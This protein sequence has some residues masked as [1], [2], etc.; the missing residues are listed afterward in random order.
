MTP[1]GRKYRYAGQREGLRVENSLVQGD[2]IQIQDAGNVYLGA[3]PV[4]CSAYVEQVKRIAP[5]RLDERDS[6]LTELAEFSVARSGRPYTWW[7]APAWA[8]KSALMSWFVLHPPPGVRVVSFFITARYKGQDHQ[9]AFTDAVMEQLADLLVEPMP[10]YLTEAT[11]EPHLLRMLSQAAEKCQG[12]DQQLALVVDGLDED[13]GVTTGPEAY[14]IAGLLPARP[15][16]GLRII[17]AGRPDPPIP[18]DVPDD[19]PL[20][21]PAIVRVLAKSQS[22]VVVKADMQRELK[23]LLHGTQAE[24]DLLGL[25]T[26]AGGGLSTEDLEELTG[27][28]GYEI[29]ETLHAVAGRTFSSRASLWQPGAAPLVYV[30]GHEELQKTAIR[31]LG[32][33]RLEEYRE[34]LHTWAEDYRQRGWPPGTPEYLLRG[35]FRMLHAARDIPRLVACATDRLRHDRMLDVT[36]GDT[37]ALAEI[38]DTQEALLGLAEPDL[39]AMGR[40]AIHRSSIVA[41][42]ARVPHVL[43]MVWA[44]AGQPERAEAFARAITDPDLKSSTLADLA[45]T[46]ARMSDVTRAESLIEMLGDPALQALA[47]ARALAALAEAAGTRDMEQAWRLGER[48]EE[49]A[50]AIGNPFVLASTLACLSH[51]AAAAGDMERATGLADRAEEAVAAQAN[52]LSDFRAL[53]LAVGDWQAL[54]LSDQHLVTLMLLAGEAANRKDLERAE[55]LARMMYDPPRQ[56]WT[57]AAVAHAAAAASETKRAGRLAERAEEA[58][59]AITD[60]GQQA[61]PLSGLA[62]AAA[63]AGDTKQ[64]GRLVERAEEAVRAITDLHEQAMTLA[65]MAQHAA[66]EGDMNWARGLAERAEEAARAITDPHEQ[67]LTLAS[68]ARAFSGTGNVEWVTGLAERA[69]EAVRAITDPDQQPLGLVMLA[70]AAAD[71]GYLEQAKRLAEQTEEVARA[72]TGLHERSRVLALLAEAVAGAGDLDRAE[73]LAQAIPHPDQQAKALAGLAQAAAD[74]GDVERARRMAER[75]E[76]LAETIHD[77]DQLSKA[78]AGL[79]QAGDLDR[80]EALAQTIPDPDQQS[81]A[82]VSLAEAAAAGGDLDRAEALAQAITHPGNRDATLAHLARVAAAGGDLERA[83][84]LAQAITMPRWQREALAGLV[85]AGDLDRAEALAQTIPDPDQQSQALVSL[86]EAAAAGGDLD[87]AEALVRAADPDQQAVNLGRLA[88]AVA[89]RGD[90][91]RAEALAQA[92][93]DQYWHSDA[94]SALAQ[95]AAAVGDLDR[96]RRLDERAEEAARAIE[97]PSWQANRLVLMARAAVKSGDMDRGEALVQAITDPW[98]YA[99]AL[100][101]LA[102][103]MLDRGDLDRAEALARVITYPNVQGDTLCSLVT[104]VAAAGDLERASGLVPLVTEPYWQARTLKALT[105]RAAATGALDKAQAAAHAIPD[106]AEQTNALEDL[107]KTA[108]E[109]GDLDRAE[110]LAQAII[111]LGRQAEVLASVAQAAAGAGDLDRARALDERAEE[112]A[113]AI[114]DAKARAWRLT[115]LARAAADK[116]EQDRAWRLAR[117][118]EESAHAIISQAGDQISRREADAIISQEEEAKLLVGLVE[119]AEPNHARSLIARILAARSWEASLDL[120]VQIVPATVITIGDEYL[121]ET[122]QGLVLRERPGPTRMT[123]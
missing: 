116:G 103:A 57:L 69:E 95:A 91:D 60:Q 74:A 58:I 73:A 41:C 56:A 94:M 118:A 113:H 62:L 70:E 28:S 52:I 123:H 59:R 51:A 100:G 92:I 67:A 5:P 1:V 85:Q 110:V 119:Y 77:P 106:L 86:A 78:L 66:G 115:S 107:A 97:D 12:Q 65:L 25:V 63:A 9:G 93:T 34:R 79:V 36:G 16:A 35:Y 108:L 53:T 42:N 33:T 18:A 27:L 80:A 61:W 11:R 26:A 43:P 71:S 2:L 122:L 17:V 7:Q 22:A 98:E 37:A 84:A 109:S 21:D 47:Q 8:G 13:R 6:E 75:A 3:G 15:P 102:E 20:R 88:E 105:E 50:Q 4:A 24:Q 45:E 29:E 23:R 68:L 76:A 30:L 31:Y 10:A 81:Q 90:L 19:H 111:H 112:A 82:L 89:A 40:L 32:K 44:K 104:A 54:M 114:G 121:N 87:R 99:K 14:S 38:A 120:L 39:V 48:A 64:A 96:A 83:E 49:A 101:D 46:A 117:Q 55:A 72:S